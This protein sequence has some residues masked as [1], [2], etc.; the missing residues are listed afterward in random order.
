MSPKGPYCTGGFLPTAMLLIHVA[1]QVLSPE[2]S[3]VKGKGVVGIANHDKSIERINSFFV[4][5]FGF[6][7]R[8]GFLCVAL[9]VPELTL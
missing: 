9:A 3:K 7:S 5:V 1:Y 6:F 2:M 8:Q 4:L